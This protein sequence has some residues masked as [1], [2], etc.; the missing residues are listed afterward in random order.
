MAGSPTVKEKGVKQVCR[1]QEGHAPTWINGGPPPDPS[2]PLN[3]L[4]NSMLSL[5]TA[6]LQFIETQD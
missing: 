1:A 5:M 4:E 3:P 6:L 2:H